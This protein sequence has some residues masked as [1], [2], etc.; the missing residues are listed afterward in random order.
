MTFFSRT[1]I[2]TVLVPLMGVADEEI[3]VFVCDAIQKVF[4]GDKLGDV[5]YEI[6]KTLATELKVL[7]FVYISN[8]WMVG[9][10]VIQ[11]Y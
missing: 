11:C 6:V 4:K 10:S 1:N 2:V 7:W 3:G 8:L 9:I 5:S